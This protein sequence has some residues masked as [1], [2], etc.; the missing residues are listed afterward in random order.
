VAP[1]L[2]ARYLRPIA[3][4]M[5]LDLAGVRSGTRMLE[6]GTGWGTLAIRAAQRGARVTTVTLSSEQ[7]RLARERVESAGLSRLVEVRVQ[8]YR[9][10][11][12]STTPSSASK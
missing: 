2:P 12:A 6:I 11:E 4:S 5:I 9:E 7:T 10:V 3:S 1:Y 8:D